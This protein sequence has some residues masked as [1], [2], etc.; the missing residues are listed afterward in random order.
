MTIGDRFSFLDA[1]NVVKYRFLPSPEEKIDKLDDISRT[2]ITEFD[3]EMN[4]EEKE[5]WVEHLLALSTEI[6]RANAIW[7]Q[8]LQEYEQPALD[9]SIDDALVDFVARRKLKLA[10]GTGQ[11]G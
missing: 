10:S 11:T 1:N 3:K 9:P 6:Q 2:F 7:K 4:S 8:L 5:P